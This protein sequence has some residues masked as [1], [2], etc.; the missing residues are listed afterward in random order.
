L[1]YVGQLIERKGVDVLLKV[2]GQVTGTELW[3][4][5]DGSLRNMVEAHAGNDDRIRVI[6]HQDFEALHELYDQVD[7]LIVPSLY[8]TWGLVVNEALEHGLPILG[9]DQVA[10][11]D[12]LVVPGKT[13]FVYEAG[14]AEALAQAIRAIQTWTTAEFDACYVAAR[15]TIAGWTYER[16]A[17][18]VIRACTIA[19]EHASESET[20]R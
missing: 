6:G 3:I 8:E 12:H 4:A 14:S 13:G 15:R 17:E 9:S 7:V 2:V 5:G 16:A 10:A 11:M 19:L 1:L 18:A 20:T